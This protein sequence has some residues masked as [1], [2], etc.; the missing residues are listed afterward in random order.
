MT[1]ARIAR[2]ATVAMVLFAAF[3]AVRQDAAPRARAPAIA[4]VDALLDE[5]LFGEPDNPDRFLDQ[6][7]TSPSTTAPQ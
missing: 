2:M 4:E 5:A 6:S 3:A 7:T 1:L